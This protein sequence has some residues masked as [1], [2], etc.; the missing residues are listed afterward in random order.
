[1]L[2]L[3]QRVRYDVEGNGTKGMGAIDNQLRGKGFVVVRN[4]F[5]E[6]SE[7]SDL[8]RWLADLEGMPHY[9]KVTSTEYSSHSTAEPFSFH[10]QLAACIA[11]DLLYF[12]I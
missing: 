3:E 2:A 5:M 9:V 12:M 7:V 4:L 8:R 11:L 6:S 10:L 1:M